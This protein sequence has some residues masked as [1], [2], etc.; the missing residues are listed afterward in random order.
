MDREL[1]ALLDAVRHLAG[2]VPVPQ[3][4]RRVV[5]AA[6]E[7]TGAR[8]G[9]LGVLAPTRD[10]LETFVYVGVDE[11]TAA[12]I[13][14]LPEGRGILGLLIRDPRPRRIDD[15]SHHPAAAGFPPH[16]PPMR[17]FLGAPVGVGETAVGNLYLCDKHGGEPFTATDE[18]LV[19]ALGTIAGVVVEHARL[20]DLARRT[21]DE[22]AATGRLTAALLAGA[23]ERELLDHLAG[24][25]VGLLG[26]QLAAILLDS[27]QGA[28]V[29]A[30]AGHTGLLGTVLPS[31]E[32]GD[33]QQA[34]GTPLLA[35]SPLEVEGRTIG[36]LA[37][38]VPPTGAE[39]EVLDHLARHGSLA[40]GYLRTVERVR[41][42]AVVEDRERIARDLH[43]TVVQRI[44]SVGLRL[45]SLARAAAAPDVAAELD[46]LVGELDDTIRDLRT[47]IFALRESM[48][49]A[50][51]LRAEVLQLA[52]EAARLLPRPPRVHFDGP[53][54]TVVGE[55][56]R[57][58]VT[59]VVREA[60]S[61]VIRHASAEVVHVTV[62]ARDGEV[63]VRVVD[64][65][66]GVAD[67]PRG[68]S[69]L[70][71]LAARARQVGGQLVVQRRAEGGTELTWR[72]PLGATG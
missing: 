31:R 25:T 68:G 41:E 49:G 53:V 71:N 23:G 19:A 2:D 36:W 65:G 70:R 30:C 6:V 14:R 45:Q 29:V 7:L 13:G 12:R 22:L 24:E 47:A 42:L 34:F 18:A 48:P 10:R 59:A 52:A 28:R 5:E 1:D 11:D 62:A 63:V 43:D 9:A 66:V 38:D 4:L 72:A 39:A 67:A 50:T 20:R 64:D 55:A 40:L 21:A 17:T 32:R 57:G 54:D 60:L 33:W 61:N 37:A 15:L 46:T 44:F 8:Y 16:H 51:S 69:G 58:H 3:L 27:G 56:L 26:C 35:V